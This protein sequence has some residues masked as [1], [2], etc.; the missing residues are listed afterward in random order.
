MI[1]TTDNCTTPVLSVLIITHNQ[2]ELLQR[3][4][5][6][7]MAQE[8]DVPF[9]V[10]ISDDRSK[11]GTRAFV[12]DRKRYYEDAK[13]N[14]VGIKYVY[15]NS[16]ECNPK[17]TSERCGW[18]KLTAY[19][20]ARGKYFVNIDAD[21]Y[22]R[23]SDIYQAQ[24][25]ML[26]AHP[27]CSMCMQRVL[28]LKEGDTYDKGDI[29]P[30]NPLLRNGAVISKEN[31]V[32]RDVRGLN[33]AY[34]IRRRPQDDMEALYGKWF[35]DTIITYHHLQFGPVVFLDRAD[36]VWVQYAHSISHC[37]NSDESIVVYG[38]LP[39]HHAKMI[40]SLR[41]LFLKQGLP[42]L[43]HM[44]KVVPKYPSFSKQYYDYLCQFDGFIYRYFIEKK[45]NVLSLLRYKFARIML[46]L[47]KQYRLTTNK[48]LDF[49]EHFLL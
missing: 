37:M 39:L 34:M 20:Q 13:R 19:E 28:S 47:I 30:I 27:D 35:D 38:L 46:L 6:S 48:W 36:Y 15:C 18:N 42:I 24:I 43:I 8:L 40:P 10:V 41:Y 33:Q 7:V 3:C 12:E 31:F 49:A 26:E 11:D 9:E 44:F 17:T 29:W 45:H 25:D 23:S 2:C 32:L 5:E 4:L 16:D 1:D 21:D 14:L 22:L